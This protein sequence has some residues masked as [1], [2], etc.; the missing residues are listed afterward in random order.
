MGAVV[1]VLLCMLRVSERVNLQL[2]QNQLSHFM[3]RLFAKRVVSLSGVVITIVRN[4]GRT[5]DLGARKVLHESRHMLLSH[6]PDGESTVGQK[7]SV[8][9]RCIPSSGVVSH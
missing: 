3:Q 1:R 4:A 5:G 7:L 8:H 9:E 6:D 2:L